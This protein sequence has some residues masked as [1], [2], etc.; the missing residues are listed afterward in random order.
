MPALEPRALHERMSLTFDLVAI[1]PLPSPSA[2]NLVLPDAPP[3][4]SYGRVVA[5]GPG[6]YQGSSQIPVPFTK[7][8]YVYF[9]AKPSRTLTIEGKKLLF[10]RAANIYCSVEE[11]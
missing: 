8:D 11:A 10:V 1:E 2:S 9:D 5:V 6:G 3:E 4:A 7:G